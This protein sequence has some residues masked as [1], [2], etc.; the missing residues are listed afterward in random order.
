MVNSDSEDEE[1]AEEGAWQPRRW[2]G[3]RGRRVL[4]SSEG[5]ETEEESA[6]TGWTEAEDEK[7]W[8]Y[9]ALYDDEEAGTRWSIVAGLLPR[10]VPRSWDREALPATAARGAMEIE[11]RYKVLQRAQALARGDG[12]LPKVAA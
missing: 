8:F 4:T 1:G 5:S 6:C 12:N 11:R 7:V 10:A 2:R 9:A 3:R